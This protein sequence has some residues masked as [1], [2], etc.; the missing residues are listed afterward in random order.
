MSPKKLHTSPREEGSPTAGP[1][2]IQPHL[3]SM[4][5]N[6]SAA[7]PSRVT[8]NLFEVGHQHCVNLADGC[9]L[10]PD[11]VEMMVQEDNKQRCNELTQSR[12]ESRD[13]RNQE[14]SVRDTDSEGEIEPDFSFD[15]NSHNE[16][17]SD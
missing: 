16:M 14:D 2:R 7:G 13:E 9:G 3:G 1:S 6:I 12:G 4:G 10:Q 17:E 15:P 11:D 5:E 8:E